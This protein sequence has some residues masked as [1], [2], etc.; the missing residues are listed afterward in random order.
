MQENMGFSTFVTTAWL[1]DYC[2]PSNEFPADWNSDFD[3]KSIF[4]ESPDLRNP[5]L[6]IS[7]AQELERIID[8]NFH[9]GLAYVLTVR[10]VEDN[11]NNSNDDE[12]CW[13]FVLQQCYVSIHKFRKQFEVELPFKFDYEDIPEDVKV[14]IESFDY[15]LLHEN[16]II[17]EESAAMD[18]KADILSGVI[19][20]TFGDCIFLTMR[21]IRN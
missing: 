1:L 3:F 20:I 8:I 13:I 16:T 17:S 10:S 14:N 15:G 2:D 6:V 9:L 21:K 5:R 11:N 4:Y 19:R 12:R 18:N 7:F